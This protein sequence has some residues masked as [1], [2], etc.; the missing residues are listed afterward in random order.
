M[1]KKVMDEME[2]MAKK[3]N[4]FKVRR[5]AGLR[6]GEGREISRTRRRTRRSPPFVRSSASSA[7]EPDLPDV[8][9]VLGRPSLA[10]DQPTI[11]R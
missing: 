1:S 10:A 5:E 8:G 7:K 11:A 4:P 2:A 6:V 9:G 3:Y